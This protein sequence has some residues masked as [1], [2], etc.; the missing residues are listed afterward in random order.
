[1]RTKREIQCVDG[2]R[3][4]KERGWDLAPLTGQDRPALEAVAHCWRLWGHSDMDGRRAAVQAIG[5]LVSGMQ[6]VCWP[7]AREL[8]AQA[9]D[10]GHRGELWPDVCDYAFRD[11][12]GSA[13][14]D[15]AAMRLQLRRCHEG[16]PLVR[17]PDDGTARVARAFPRVVP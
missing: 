1:M 8:A 7:M 3:W 13:V 9:L 14:V 6:P 17:Q 11:L 5:A 15:V 16:L 4:L 12:D 10:W 2:L